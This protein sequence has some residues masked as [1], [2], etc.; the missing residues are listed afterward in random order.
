MRR[1]RRQRLAAA[2]KA[3]PRYWQDG[4]AFTKVTAKRVRGYRSRRLGKFGPASDVRHVSPG[5]GK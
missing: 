3:T 5:E 1:S 2:A 4:V